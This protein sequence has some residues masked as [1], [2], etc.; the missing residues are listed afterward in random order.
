MVNIKLKLVQ[1]RQEKKVKKTKNISV[2]NEKSLKQIIKNISEKN[3]T[4]N[5]W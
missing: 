2:K 3:I 1:V 4:I 5:E